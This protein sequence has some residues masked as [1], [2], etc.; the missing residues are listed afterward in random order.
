MSNVQT[1]VHFH[2]EQYWISRRSTDLHA[3]PSSRRE[4]WPLHAITIVS[5][6]RDVVYRLANREL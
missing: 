2:R 6:N 5:E 1:T 4:R 3:R